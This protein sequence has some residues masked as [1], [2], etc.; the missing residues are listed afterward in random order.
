MKYLTIFL[1]LFV[2]VFLIACSSSSAAAPNTPLK[3]ADPIPAGKQITN[4]PL[5]SIP[6]ASS[7]DLF[8]ITK[9][10]KDITVTR[11]SQDLLF[12]NESVGTIRN[13]WGLDIRNPNYFEFEAKVVYSSDN[14]IWYFPVSSSKKNSEVIKI[15]NEFENVIWPKTT[16]LFAPELKL[17]GKIAIVH[18]SFPGLGGYF[19]PSDATPQ[20]INRY[21]NLRMG[22]YLNEPVNLTDLSYLG[23]LTH[24]LQHLLHWHFDKNEEVWLQEG[25][26]ELA[27]RTL[28]YQALPF[29]TFLKKPDVSITHWPTSP[30][31][32]LPNYAA[33]SLFAGYLYQILQSSGIASLVADPLNGS[34]GI[35]KVLG[36]RGSDKTFEKIFHDWLIANYLNNRG[37]EYSYSYLDGE[38]QPQSIIT[39][40]Q[41]I[42]G[43]IQQR[44]AW[45]T[46]FKS[47][48]ELE[49]TFEGEKAT[50]IL[51][52][53]P[54]SGDKCWWSNRG[55]SINSQLTRTFDLSNLKTASLNFKSWWDI[56]K[57]WDHGYVMVSKDLGKNWNI[58]RGSRSSI[59]NPLGTAFG[60][61]YT[62]QS[63]KWRNENIDLT[64]YV[65]STILLRFEYITDEA[66]NTSGWCIDD[67]S[68]TELGFFDD[69]E[70]SDAT[71]ISNGF[72]KMTSRGVR[73]TFTLIH[74]NNK[75]AASKF[76]LSA[77]NKLSFSVS[78]P[79]TLII[80]ASAPKTSEY[81]N[82]TL[83][84]KSK[85]RGK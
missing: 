13:F 9:R 57:E 59:K 31:E 51:P 47:Q 14:A 21:S 29:S 2:P 77:S 48:E 22:I 54:Y 30:G 81:A 49:V 39:A 69:F 65:G 82:F 25:L 19:Q 46:E 20:S 56:E 7:S 73:Q 68:I 36:L 43:S 66:I 4:N 27:A 40:P 18:G 15:V 78:Q 75:N 63:K 42:S 61:S 70:R 34:A 28:N 16:K 11:P 58:L 52:V 26:S 6:D 33:A 5:G 44:G 79:S 74:I 83:T 24:E 80:T 35:N 38:I 3:T 85:T 67:L 53:L 12:A 8:A 37:T 55:D 1:S 76:P 45:Y 72:I 50:A 60:P 41:E 17:P 23:T 10:L 62:G 64:P 71:W 32:S 84:I